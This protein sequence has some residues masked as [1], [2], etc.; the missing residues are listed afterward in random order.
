MDTKRESGS[1]VIARSPEDLYDM[2][3]DVTRM[4]E[5]SPECVGGSWD[6]GA[7]PAVA[8]WFTGKNVTPERQWEKRCEVVVADRGREFAWVTEGTGTRW[9]Y[10]F[11]AVDGGTEVTETWEF[12]PTAVRSFEERFGEDAETVIADRVEVTRKGIA[13]TL[14]TLKAA[15]ED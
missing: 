5:W 6:A 10:A 8:S 15:A 13:S 14:A 9:S 1:I 11:A 4:G 7:G 2:I 3:A 12:G